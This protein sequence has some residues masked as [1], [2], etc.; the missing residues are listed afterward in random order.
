MTERSGEARHAEAG[1][2]FPLR[3]A[4]MVDERAV[5]AADD[6]ADAGGGTAA[7]EAGEREGSER[8]YVNAFAR[9][10]EVIRVFSRERPRLTLSEVA[11]ATAMTRATVRRFLLTLVRDGYA[12]SDGKHFWLL[13]KV[14]ELGFAALSS[15]EIWD[16]AQPIMN[17]LAEELQESC[18]AAVLEGDSVIY[19]ARAASNRFVNVGLTIGSRVSAH[20]V[21]TGRVLLA[22]LPDDKLHDLLDRA[23]FEKLTPH[24]VTSK[25]KLLALIQEVRQRGWAVVDQELEIGLRSLSV[26][27]RDRAGKT[28]AALNVCCPSLRITPQD[29]RSRVLAALLD[30]SSRITAALR[31]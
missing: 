29:M 20:C 17:A 3:R 5:P 8:D 7:A 2:R 28:V 26:P 10:L 4:A 18:F 21:S 31:A 25:V 13:P 12:A 14:L 6:A 27:V 24:T 22:A 1:T 30:A 16:V 23:R 11:L 15:M 9:G 19:V